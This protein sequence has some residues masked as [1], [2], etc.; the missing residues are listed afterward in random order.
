MPRSRSFH[1]C[2]LVSIDSG[3]MHY[4]L[5]RTLLSILRSFRMDLI[6]KV[7]IHEYCHIQRREMTH[8]TD[9]DLDRQLF[10]AK[11]TEP[12]VCV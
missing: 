10:W 9:V 3:R 12:P 8:Q 5:P 1:P 4:W 7:E 6:G 11:E 2:N